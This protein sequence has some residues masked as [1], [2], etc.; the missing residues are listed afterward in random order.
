MKMAPWQLFAV[1]GV[2][3]GVALACGDDDTPGAGGSELPDAGSDASDSG[4]GG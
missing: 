4:D 1:L 2:T 3:S